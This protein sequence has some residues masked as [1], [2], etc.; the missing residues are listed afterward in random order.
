MP[1]IASTCV[2]QANCR[3]NRLLNASG[4]L[5]PTASSPWLRRIITGIVAEVANQ[6]RALVDVDREP[7]VVVVA[8][9]AVEQ[10][11]VLAEREEP[12]LHGGDRDAGLGMGVDDAVDVLAAA[13]DRA[14]DDEARLVHGRVGLVDQ[15]AVEIDL[16]QVRRRHLVEQ[17][18][19]AVEQEMP[20]SP[21]T[22]AEMWV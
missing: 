22:R 15:V 21:G 16:D 13:V 1:A 20:G 18:P 10:L 8:H 5:G 6:P 4:M 7:L 19:E 14:V 12:V 17:E 9:A 2:S 3:L 11:R